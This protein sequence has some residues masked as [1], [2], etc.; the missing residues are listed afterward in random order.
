VLASSYTNFELII[1][2]DASAD[3]TVAIVQ[4]Y[5]LKDSRIQLYV[6]EQ[7]LG[8]YVNRNKVAGFA[9]GKYIKYVD[10]DDKIAV[11]GLQ[12]MVAAMEMYPQA[13]LG[14]MQHEENQ[15]LQTPLYPLCITP[16][17]AYLQH[18]NGYGILRY[19]PTGTII[20]RDIFFQL[21]CFG[22]SRF[23]GDTE[24]W[25]KLAAKYPIVKIEP[26]VVWWRVHQGQEY[27]IG[28]KQFAYLRYSYPIFISSLQSTQCPLKNS[29]VKRI[30]LR[31]KWKHARDILNLAMV[32][33]MPLLAAT[34][35]KESR[36]NLMDIFT[37][38]LPYNRLK[39]KF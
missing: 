39:R 38:M 35:F 25:L 13:A 9:K 31:L 33:R 11:D 37:G 2:D 22:T 14:I 23:L 24:F 18:Y 15:T 36:F 8:D 30:V 21:N 29:D 16:E 28:H 26:G 20:R 17:Q 6:N 3:N 5:L 34:I 27:D 1:C 32:R 10:S 4:S 19:G 12:K 7:N